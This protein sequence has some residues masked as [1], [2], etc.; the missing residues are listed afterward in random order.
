M[1]DQLND[2][3]KNETDMDLMKLSYQEY[4]ANFPLTSFFMYHGSFTTPS[5]DG[6][7]VNIK[8]KILK[9][10]KIK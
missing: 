5:C 8:K 10:W 2:P 1:L 3:R 9:E 6:I 4:D 7:C